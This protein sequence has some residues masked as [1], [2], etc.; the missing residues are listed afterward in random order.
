MNPQTAR[1][2]FHAFRL[3]D[4]P[5]I[6]TNVGRGMHNALCVLGS[7]LGEAALQLVGVILEVPVR[8]L[9]YALLRTLAIA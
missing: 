9:G 6:I 3:S 2:P 5:W 4:P 1:S 8:D 7:I